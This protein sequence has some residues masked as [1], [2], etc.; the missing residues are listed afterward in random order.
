MDDDEP[1]DGEEAEARRV[2]YATLLEECAKRDDAIDAVN[3]A[4]RAHPDSEGAES[5]ARELEREEEAGKPASC[6]EVFAIRSIRRS[7]FAS[8]S[9]SRRL[10]S[11]RHSPPLSA[12]L[13][14]ALAVASNC[15]AIIWLIASTPPVPAPPPSR[16]STSN[17][18][19]SSPSA[20]VA[21]SGT[22]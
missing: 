9:A 18:A 4:L 10:V 8:T 1:G 22:A 21:P 11:S 7:N 13:T 15:S 20:I 17:A 16:C 19:P 6:D 2:T 14:S 5:A 3:D 12:S